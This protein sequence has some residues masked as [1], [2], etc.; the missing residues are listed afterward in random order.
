ISRMQ[1]LFNIVLERETSRKFEFNESSFHHG[2]IYTQQ[3][4]NEAA[5]LFSGQ[6]TEAKKTD[7]VN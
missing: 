6:Y 1:S 4:D 5:L 7:L 2:Y 3:L